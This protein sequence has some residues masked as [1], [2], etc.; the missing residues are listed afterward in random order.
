[1]TIMNSETQTN[2]LTPSETKE[3]LVEVKNLKKYFPVKGGILKRTIGHVKAVENVTLSIYQGETLGLVGESGSGKSTLGHLILKLLDP[4]EGKI[5]FNGKDI[6]SYSQRKIRPYRKNMQMIFQDPY[7]SLNPRM[8]VGDLIEEPL[9]LHDR[10]TKKERQ[11]RI[12]ELLHTVGLDEET[13]FKY[14][15]EF[16]GGQLQ[17]IGIARALSSRPS[18]VIGDEPVSLL[19]V[20]VQSQVLHLMSDLQ[21]KFNLTYLFISHDLSVVKHMCDRIAVMYLGR[22]AEVAPKHSLYKEPL[23]PYTKALIASVPGVDRKRE[24]VKLEGNMPSPSNHPAGCPFHTRCPESHNR[25]TVERPELINMGND[26]YV[27]CHLYTE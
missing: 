13:R 23:H 5:I 25:C 26:H 19:D 4:T 14:P 20:S 21:I 6:T 27:A 22:I 10:L 24:K 1:M 7:S 2:S 3:K 16:S 12:I 9:I 17:R 18:L 11:N 8:S 15:H